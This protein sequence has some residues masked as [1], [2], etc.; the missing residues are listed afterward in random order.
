MNTT[1]MNIPSNR[2]SDIIRYCKHQLNEIYPSFEVDIYI[3]MLF[4][5]YLDWSYPQLLLNK[6]KTINQ[7]D[8]LKFHWAVE[9]LKRQKPIQYIIGETEFCDCK[10]KVTPDVL[11]PRPETEEI[12]LHTAKYYQSIS[13]NSKRPSIL[14]ICTGSGCIAIALSKQLQA[15]E[16]IGIDISNAALSIAKENAEQNHQ[17]VQFI[18][19]DILSNETGVPTGP[20]DIII[21]NPPYVC[22]REREQMSRNVLDYEPPIAL[23]VD[24]NNPLIFYKAIATLAISRLAKEGILVF[25]INEAYG[26]ETLDMLSLVGFA[27][28]LFKDF[29]EKHRY[30]IAQS[31]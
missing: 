19:L 9:D 26:Q 21:S 8:L 11:I 16:T 22:Q 25:E 18:E 31:I 4:E 28:K 29:R 12:I 1:Q 14:D 2:V 13:N 6:E 17:N 3:R 30:I 23:F 24:D 15:K 27:G 20:F 7:S 10:I 5:A